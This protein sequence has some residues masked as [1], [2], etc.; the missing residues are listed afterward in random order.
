LLAMQMYAT[1]LHWLQLHYIEVLATISG[2]LYV[3]YTIRE[4]NLL[5][6]FGII[7]SGLFV[8]VFYSSGIFAYATLYIYYVLIGI[9][10]WYNWSRKIPDMEGRQGNIV[11]RRGS[12]AVIFSCLAISILLAVPLYFI[13]KEYTDSDIALLDAILTSSGMVATWMLTQKIIEQWLFWIVIDLLSFGVMILK[14][15]YPSS[16][17]F[18]AY[19]FLAVKGYFE[20]KKALMHPATH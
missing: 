15:L 7:S 12:V 9:Y 18:L 6:L 3:I 11:I 17:L 10:G 13:L 1:A 14:G 16:L 2:L 20:W 19:T 5:W 4:N 8:F